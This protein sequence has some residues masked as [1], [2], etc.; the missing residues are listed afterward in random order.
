MVGEKFTNATRPT[1]L[2]DVVMSQASQPTVR[3]CIHNAFSAKTFPI[4]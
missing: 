4:R 3:R 1:K 2:A